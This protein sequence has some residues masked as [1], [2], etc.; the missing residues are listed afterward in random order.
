M[1][2]PQISLVVPV[3]N[4]AGN[5]KGLIDAIRGAAPAWRRSWEAIIVD[6]G[7]C[8]KTADIAGALVRGDERFRIV[9]LR[10]NAGQTPAMVAGFDAAA[11][12][13]IVTMDG[14]LQN[15]P[16]DI[17]LLLQKID[18]GFDVASGWRHDRQDAYWTRTFPSRI[19]NR[20]ISLAT[21]V[22]L[23]DYG[24]SLK[25]YRAR[26]LKSLPFYSEMHRFFPAIVATVLGAHVTEVKV[27]HYPRRAGQS[28][29]GLSRTFRVVADLVTVQF[30][31]RFL[32]HPVYWFGLM[33]VPFAAVGFFL[34]AW[35]AT[36]YRASGGSFVLPS[37]SFLVLS[38]AFHFLV[39]GLL[40]EYI[41]KTGEADHSTRIAVSVHP[42]EGRTNGKRTD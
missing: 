42:I 28:K 2:A 36:Q 5:V 29:Y 23:H 14:D 30:L 37:I 8:D 6:D 17:P 35:T 10:R 9:R 41:L 19:A 15:D 7:S 40:S 11:G 26:F 16:A 25:A 34:L 32:R 13:I 24:C 22:R 38:A 4:E 20:L 12:E 33:A 3:F 18:Q 31:A 39:Q 27:R 1:G 21:G